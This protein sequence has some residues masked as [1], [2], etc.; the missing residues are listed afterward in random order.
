MK[1]FLFVSHDAN[2][3]GAQ[4]FLLNLMVYLKQQGHELS[5]LLL[6]GG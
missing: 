6:G 2:R 5:L 3:A 1:H 4:L